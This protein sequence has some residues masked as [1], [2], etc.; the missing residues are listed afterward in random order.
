MIQ[1]LFKPALFIILLI[2]NAIFTQFLHDQLQENLQK[3]FINKKIS[4]ALLI[5]KDK[6]I[7]YLC[8]CIFI[9]ILLITYFLIFHF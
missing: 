8:T 7:K 9:M 3:H 2:F 6:G 5:K 4:I 1:V